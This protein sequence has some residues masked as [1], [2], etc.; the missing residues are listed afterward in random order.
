MTIYAD[1]VFLANFFGDWLCLW[2]CSALYRHIPVW[3]RVAAAVLG[4]L[5]GVAAAV[6][7]VELLGSIWAKLLF[8]LPIGAAAYLPARPG[9]IARGTGAFLLASFL[10]CGAVELADV[11]G[12]AVRTVLAVFGSACILICGISALKSR[13][14]ARYLPCELCF[15]GRKVRYTGFYDSGNRLISGREGERVI[16]ADE[17]IIK[18][19]FPSPPP[20]ERVTDIPF[21]SCANGSMKGVKLD[22]A[23]VDGR[24]YDDVVL[25]ISETQLAD[26]LVLHSTMI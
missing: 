20:P 9:E 8:A 21:S 6:S 4:G 1:L 18:K 14:Y 10:L 19:L 26:G 11:S 15:S 13:I 12:G 5:Y 17:R 2:L 23:K 22:Y 3:R 16:I 25:A 24:R 7:G